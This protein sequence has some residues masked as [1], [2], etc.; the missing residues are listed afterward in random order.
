M[1]N[2]YHKIVPKIFM[3]TIAKPYEKG[4]HIDVKKVKKKLSQI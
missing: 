1:T 3:N 4:R 2:I